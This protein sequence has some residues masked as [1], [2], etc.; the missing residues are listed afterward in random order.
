MLYRY[1]VDSDPV[2]STKPRLASARRTPA[3]PHTSRKGRPATMAALFGPWTIPPLPST[4]K[5][6]KTR[7]NAS[8]PCAIRAE[9]RE[10]LFAMRGTGKG[11]RAP[12]KH[13]TNKRCK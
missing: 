7:L 1:R 9:R 3:A 8:T 12:K 11:A 13:F 2:P 6:L 4:K 5:S 10:V